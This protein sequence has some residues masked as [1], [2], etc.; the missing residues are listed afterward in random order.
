M[1]RAELDN[2]VGHRKKTVDAQPNLDYAK[3]KG[4]NSA[5]VASRSAVSCIVQKLGLGIRIGGEKKD[6]PYELLS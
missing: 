4:L 2:L 6:R 1:S 3:N 5:H